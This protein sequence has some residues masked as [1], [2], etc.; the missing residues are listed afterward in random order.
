ME[1]PLWSMLGY[2]YN[3]TMILIILFLWSSC[4]ASIMKFSQSWVYAGITRMVINWS[5]IL[6]CFGYSLALQL[7]V[8]ALNMALVVVQGLFEPWSHSLSFVDCVG[9]SFT[10]YEP[11]SAFAFSTGKRLPDDPNDQTSDTHLNEGM[12]NKYKHYLHVSHFQE[13]CGLCLHPFT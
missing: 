13:V 6:A 3:W 9:V 2:G 1:M 7:R 5:W 12:A 10:R 11:M 4:C 8:L